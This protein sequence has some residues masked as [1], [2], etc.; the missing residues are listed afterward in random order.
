MFE[1]IINKAE[2]KMSKENYEKFLIEVITELFDI[3]KY[4]NYKCNKLKKL[5]KEL[6]D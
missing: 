1:K 5:Y 3:K 4:V 2:K 6:K